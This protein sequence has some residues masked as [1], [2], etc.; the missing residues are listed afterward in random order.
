MLGT[1][2][3][4]F[5]FFRVFFS[6]SCT[7]MTSVSLIAVWWPWKAAQ[8]GDC[9]LFQL[10]FL[11]SDDHRQISAG[12]CLHGSVCLFFSL[13]CLVRFTRTTTLHGIIFPSWILKFIL[14][15]TKKKKKNLWESFSSSFTQHFLFFVIV[16]IIIFWNLHSWSI[17]HFYTAEAAQNMDCVRYL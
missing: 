1:K 3:L 10:L 6:L 14:G 2:W 16:S 4:C 13:M 15:G 11:P 9:C 5:E 17:I 12:T 8:C 7:K